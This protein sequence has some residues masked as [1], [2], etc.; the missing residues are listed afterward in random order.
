MPR[1][2]EEAWSAAEAAPRDAEGHVD[3]D[4]YMAEYQ[5]RLAERHQRLRTRGPGR[6]PR[7]GRLGASPEPG[8]MAADRR[9]RPPRIST[10]VA[11]SWTVSAPSG[12]STRS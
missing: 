11:S 12:T 2:E 3:L 1:A 6:L 9:R 10:A 4:T 5:Q 8:R 7:H